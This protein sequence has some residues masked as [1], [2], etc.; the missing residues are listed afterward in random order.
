MRRGGD[1]D[2]ARLSLRPTDDA[3][4]DLRLMGQPVGALDL[5]DVEA[6]HLCSGDYAR[7]CKVI[8]RRQLT[9]LP[10]N[11]RKLGL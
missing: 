4:F 2:A 9:V 5:A 3:A 10:S 7:S 1:G 8:G 6:S 11:L